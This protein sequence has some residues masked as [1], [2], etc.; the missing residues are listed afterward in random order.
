MQA[1]LP[2]PTRTSSV[3]TDKPPLT[4]YLTAL[5]AGRHSVLVEICPSLSFQD[6]P[7][8]RCFPS[9][10]PDLPRLSV[11]LKGP[12]SPSRPPSP[13][14]LKGT[15]LSPRR[16]LRALL[17]RPPGVPWLQLGPTDPSSGPVPLLT[18]PLPSGCGLSRCEPAC[19]GESLACTLQH[20]PRPPPPAPPFLCSD[21]ST[22]T[23]VVPTPQS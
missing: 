16:Q 2:A 10:L 1:S 21:R 7:F 5:D 17:R 4:L 19:P 11:F 6:S 3:H 22:A 14:T 15:L 8:C 13:G 9:S 12:V 18:A 20:V 23:R